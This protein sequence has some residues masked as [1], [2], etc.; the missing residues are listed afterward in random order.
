MKVSGNRLIAL[1]TT[2]AL[3]LGGA[4]PAAS[5]AATAHAAKRPAHSRVAK[6]PSKRTACRATRANHR[7]RA[8]RCATTRRRAA[9]PARRRPA[10]GS[11]HA[12]TRSGAGTKTQH[13]RPPKVRRTKAAAPAAG[14]SAKSTAAAIAAALAIH[15]EGTELQP[16]EANLAQVRAATLCLINQTR[17]RHGVAPLAE[18]AALARAAD[19]HGRELVARDYFA[20]VTPEGYTPVDRIRADGYVPSPQDGYVIGENLAWGTLSLSTPASIVAAWEASPEHLAN[21]LEGQYTE[22]GIGVAPAAPPS[23]AEGQSGATYAQE[24]GTIIK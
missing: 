9:A 22:T 4:A 19:E 23:L 15:C 3:A 20:H 14:G 21:I 10:G 8:S 12:K 18:N 13:T 11:A 24:F 16:Q 2:V 7:A 5:P 6:R 1:L 17:G